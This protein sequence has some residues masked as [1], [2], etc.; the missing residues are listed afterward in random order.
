M[1]PMESTPRCHSQP[2]GG[3]RGRLTTGSVRLCP[4][5]GSGKADTAAQGAAAEQAV[6]AKSDPGRIDIICA[7]PWLRKPDSLALALLFCD[8]RQYAVR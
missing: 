7:S 6:G 1:A 5:S 4:G 3:R 8:T 2:V